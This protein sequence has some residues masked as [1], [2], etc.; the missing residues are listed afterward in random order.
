MAHNFKLSLELP[1]RF[2]EPLLAHYRCRTVSFLFWG[3]NRT[4]HERNV[5]TNIPHIRVQLIIAKVAVSYMLPVNYS[6][7]LDICRIG[8]YPVLS[9]GFSSPWESQVFST[10][11]GW[12]DKSG[13]GV[14]LPLSVSPWFQTWRAILVFVCKCGRKLKLATVNLYENCVMFL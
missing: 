10:E 13:E 11:N 9:L 6:M 3:C 7:T 14:V 2:L 5:K 1:G 8:R 12:M 4:L